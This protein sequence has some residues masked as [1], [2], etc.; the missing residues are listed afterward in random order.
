MT[1]DKT[2]DWIT[3]VQRGG[4]R[5][6]LTHHRRGGSN[7]GTPKVDVNFGKLSAALRVKALERE[8]GRRKIPG[9]QKT[10]GHSFPPK[11]S[12]PSTNQN[13]K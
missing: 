11:R 8:N 4:D 3:G 6:K 13:L 10:S 2:T 7:L 1:F 5:G 12:R 9:G